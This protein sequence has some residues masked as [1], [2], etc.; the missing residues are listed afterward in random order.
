MLATGATTSTGA[1]VL[2]LDIV[3]LGALAVVV[4][5]VTAIRFN[6]MKSSYFWHFN[7]LITGKA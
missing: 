7:Y 6:R 2:A 3:A 4:M 1:H 5:H